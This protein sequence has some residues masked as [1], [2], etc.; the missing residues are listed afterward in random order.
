MIDYNIYINNHITNTIDFF[1]NFNI[2][3]KKTIK[4][5][6]LHNFYNNDKITFNANKLYIITRNKTN[7]YNLEILIFDFYK[8]KFNL[9]QNCGIY[10]INNNNCK[11][12]LI[13]FYSHKNS[14]ILF[15]NIFKKINYYSNLNIGENLNYL[16]N[17]NISYLYY[18]YGLN[19][20]WHFYY[21]L[22]RLHN[23]YSIFLLENNLI[24][25]ENYSFD[26]NNIIKYTKKIYNN[27]NIKY[28]K[29][30]ILKI[31]SYIMGVL[32]KKLDFDNINNFINIHNSKFINN[33]CIIISKNIVGYGGNQKKARQLYYNL[34]KYYNVRIWSVAP[35]KRGKFS[36]K[37]DS[38][39]QSIHLSDIVKL[40]TYS[41]IIY[42][43]NRNNFDI[44]INN[45]LNEFFN[46]S[47]KINNKNFYIIT[48]NSMDPFNKLILDNKN[49]IQK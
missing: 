28:N 19:N 31:Y 14:N 47:N 44:I 17:K 37:N 20:F 38:I 42:Y 39:C 33:K 16:S 2:F 48:H 40:K 41:E 9:K 36:F 46:F 13:I 7:I 24:D 12:F 22:D 11:E 15:Q 10:P 43:I 30:H 4:Y 45:K 32:N 8:K 3:K 49:I 27:Q 35:V 34:E 6:N 23:L 5:I 25:F 26:S 1:E 29:S 18:I 21:P